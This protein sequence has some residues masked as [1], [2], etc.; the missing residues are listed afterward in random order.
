MELHVEFLVPKGS[1]SGVY[2]M[3]GDHGPVAY[4]NLRVRP[5][6]LDQAPGPL[7]RKR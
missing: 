6:R 7:A 4:R 5:V 1:D 2:L 3:Q